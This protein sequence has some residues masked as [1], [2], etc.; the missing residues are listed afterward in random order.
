MTGTGSVDVST[1]F[2]PQDFFLPLPCAS[3]LAQEHP[4]WGPLHR[5]V[6]LTGYEHLQLCPLSVISLCDTFVER[7]SFAGYRGGGGCHTYSRPLFPGLQ[8]E[9]CVRASPGPPLGRLVQS[10]GGHRPL[11]TT[12]AAGPLETGGPIISLYWLVSLTLFLLP[13]LVD[14]Q[15]R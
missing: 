2:T 14:A 1:Q 4:D 12:R 6:G 9:F 10:P 15:V 7:L 8:C 13:G 11:P 5:S 3:H